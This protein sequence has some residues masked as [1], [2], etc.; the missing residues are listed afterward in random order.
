MPRRRK[1]WQP[2]IEHAAK[3]VQTHDTAVTLPQLS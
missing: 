1:V 2:F 3:T